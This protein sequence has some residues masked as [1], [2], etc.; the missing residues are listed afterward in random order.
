[1][2]LGARGRGE[3]GLL[4]ERS[5]RS[6]YHS[7]TSSPPWSISKGK[8]SWTGRLNLRPSGVRRLTVRTLWSLPSCRPSTIAFLHMCRGRT[9]S[10][11]TTT[12]PCVGRGTSVAFGLR[13][14]SSVEEGEGG[15]AG[16]IRVARREV[17]TISISFL[18]NTCSKSY[19]W[20]SNKQR[21]QVCTWYPYFQPILNNTGNCQHILVL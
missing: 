5:W 2:K 12:S 14:S 6:Q 15:G 7:S 19:V 9:S 16:G 13:E 18:H 1:M 17:M 21:M 8:T 4:G 10:W 11:I 3:S 20:Y